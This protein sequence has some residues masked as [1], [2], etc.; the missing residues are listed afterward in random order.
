LQGL[1]QKTNR[2]TGKTTH[3]RVKLFKKR[4]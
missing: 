2:N 1:S 4:R 3:L